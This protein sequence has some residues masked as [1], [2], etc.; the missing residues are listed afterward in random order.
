VT[1]PSS[2]GVWFSRYDP[3]PGRAGVG[4][5]ATPAGHRIA[6]RYEPDREAWVRIRRLLR[7]ALTVPMLIG[8]LLLVTAGPAAACTYPIP[9]SETTNAA[10]ADAVFVGTLRSQVNRTNWAAAAARDELARELQRQ[11]YRADRI[12]ELGRKVAQSSDRAVLT[13]EV[14]RVYKGTVGKRQEVITFLAPSCPPLLSG[15]GPF[16]IFANKPPPA[17]SRQYKLG[18]GQYTLGLG[19][20]ALAD[21]GEPDLGR[22]GWLAPDSIV[23]GGA[24]LAAGIAAGLALASLRA[25]RR[26][27]AS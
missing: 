9:A 2:P 13:F 20:R 4:E 22:P 19:S 5:L 17:T 8:G 1:R 3:K 16:L 10:R 26:P 18:H 25:R 11:P 6:A 14:R 7:A 12:A 21:G 27:S 24:V 23:V 15:P